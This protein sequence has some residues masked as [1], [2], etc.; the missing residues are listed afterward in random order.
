VGGVV[1][2]FLFRIDAEPN[3]D[4]WLW[5]VVGDLPSCYLVTDRASDGIKA[6]RRTVKSWRIGSRRPGRRAIWQKFFL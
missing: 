6:S 1:S 3:I 5:V 4:E 2:T